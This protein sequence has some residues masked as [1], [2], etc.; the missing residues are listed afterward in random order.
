MLHG[1][2]AVQSQ[3]VTSKAVEEYAEL[4]TKGKAKS[5]SALEELRKR[6]KIR[7]SLDGRVQLLSSKGK[8]FSVRLDMEVPGAMLLREPDLGFVYAVQTE[9][10][11]QID[12]SDDYVL[13]LMFA[14]SAW[15][16]QMSPVSYSDENGK[17]KQLK[18]DEREFREVVGLLKEAGEEDGRE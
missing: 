9:A 13:L 17:S 1:A 15:E 6:Y 8:W 18:L 7:R 4:E 2:A 11:Q 16:E 5:V 14:D 10:L 3:D 12:L